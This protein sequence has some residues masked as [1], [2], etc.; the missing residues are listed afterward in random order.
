MDEA[1]DRAMA[2][3]GGDA[4]MT[5][6][7]SG[8][9]QLMSSTVDENGNVVTSIVRFDINQNNAGVQKLGEHLNLETQINGVKVRSGPLAAPHTPIDPSTIRPGDIP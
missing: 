2:H 9:F 6:S 3:T 1:I 5:V 7:S 4:P 8:G